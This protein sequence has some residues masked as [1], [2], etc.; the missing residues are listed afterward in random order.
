MQKPFTDNPSRLAAI[1][2]GTHPKAAP[3]GLVTRTKPGLQPKSFRLRPDD[4][5]RLSGL[6]AQLNRN[7]TGRALTEIDAIRGLLVLGTQTPPERLL[8]AVRDGMV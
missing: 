1:A 2:A 5:E 6:V 7:R 3:L 8:R 4:L